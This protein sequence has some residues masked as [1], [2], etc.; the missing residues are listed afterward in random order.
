MSKKFK[1]NL[2][3]NIPMIFVLEGQ[4]ISYSI[5]DVSLSVYDESRDCLDIGVLV[6][7]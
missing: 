3:E 7:L 5:R 6:C 2:E 1:F 4:K